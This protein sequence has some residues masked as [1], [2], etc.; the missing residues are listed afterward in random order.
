MKV[1]F[2]TAPGYGL[3]LPLVPLM[4]A[5]R[6]AGHEVLLATTS[7]MVAVGAAAGL[8]VYDVFPERDVWGEVM[9]RSSRAR[10]PSS[11]VWPD[12]LVHFVVRSVGPRRVRTA[13]RP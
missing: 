4:W 5:A 9:A 10:P 6:A 11:I 2:A 12:G 1:L 8:A 7:D 3:T 13:D